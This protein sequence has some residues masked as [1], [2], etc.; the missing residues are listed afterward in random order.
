MGPTQT[1]WLSLLQRFNRT[2]YKSPHGLGDVAVLWEGQRSVHRS[3]CWWGL[4]PG[5]P[6]EKDLGGPGR[7]WEALER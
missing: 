2:L 3:A 5:G 7:R 6:R 4:A 1:L